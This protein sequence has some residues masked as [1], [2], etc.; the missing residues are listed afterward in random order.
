MGAPFSK[1]SLP[2]NR[3]S[4]E[5]VF[6]IMILRLPLNLLKA[7]V[8]YRNSKKWT[9]DGQRIERKKNMKINLPPSYGVFV[10][11]LLY[12]LNE[13]NNNQNISKLAYCAINAVGLMYLYQAYRTEEENE[14][15]QLYNI[16]KNILFIILLNDLLFY[17]KKI[18]QKN[19]LSGVF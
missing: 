14:M 13:I 16:F 5:I 4:I 1:L 9:S 12:I 15:N 2:D 8:Q 7:V 18:P 17:L 11:L 19:Y 3:Q 10:P 6:I